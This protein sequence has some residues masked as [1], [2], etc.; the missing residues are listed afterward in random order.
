THLYD[1]L[2]SVMVKHLKRLQGRKAIVLFTDGVDASSDDHSYED[3][4]RLAEELDAL[5]YPVRYDTSGDNGNISVG[6]S[7][8]QPPMSRPRLPGILRKLPLPMPG[9]TTVMG[10][11]AGASRADYA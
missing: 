8:P 6:T 1:A 2:N 11:P 4:F 5:I 3:N 9:G 7:T 10:G